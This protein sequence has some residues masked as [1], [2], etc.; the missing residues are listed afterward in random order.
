MRARAA[1]AL[2]VAGCLYASGTVACADA[3]AP[4]VHA[5]APARETMT[6]TSVVPDPTIVRVLGRELRADSVLADQTIGVTSDLG[7]VSLEGNVDSR[8]AKQ[9]AVEI[10]HIVRGVR[11][12]VDR[13]EVVPN[14]RP[15]YE[16][17]FA[18][19]SGLSRDPVVG[20]QH[21]ASRA[22]DGVIHLSG[23]VDS[24]GTRRVAERDALAIPGVQDVVDELV[25]RPRERR[26]DHIAATASRLLRDDPW[27]DGSRVRAIAD[28]AT[29]RLSG[30]V[31]SAEEWTRAEADAA[32]ASPLASVDITGLAID[33][34]MDDGTL[35]GRTAATRT[36]G[37]IGQAVLDA[38]VGDPRVHPFVPT[39]EVHDGA[40][41][42]TGVAP[43]PE[44]ARAA[45]DDARN[46]VGAV[47]VH[48]D[49]KVAP[50]LTAA[51]DRSVLEQVK[52]ALATD[53]N[54]GREPI[55]VNV[56]NGRVFLRGTVHTEED[57]LHAI[58]LATSAPGA[59]DVSD[60]LVLAAPRLGVTSAQ[61]Q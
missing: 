56:Q 47:A 10:G 4:P 49:L 59:R 2:A 7:I 24:E 36:D 61:P 37:D 8:L 54:L 13:I 1:R 46:V 27:L 40:V 11:A 38:Y 25:L 50:A 29:V 42:L 26:D 33:H 15:D 32:L 57:R 17:E 3:P 60:G 23:G 34:S 53:P 51:T 21:I 14:P 12:I 35:R 19:A 39:V 28:H 18:V 9:R 44:A 5:P 52:S 16:L 31:G 48:D 6:S 41:I 45:D 20:A 55:A 22:K 30:S 58:S 43:N